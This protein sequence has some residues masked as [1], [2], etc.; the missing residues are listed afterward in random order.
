MQV[1]LL[2]NKKAKDLGWNPTIS[3]EE[4]ILD[5]FKKESK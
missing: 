1:I 2:D 5:Y 4:G 3:L